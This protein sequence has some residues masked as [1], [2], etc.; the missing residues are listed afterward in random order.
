MASPS[1]LELGPA[2]LLP[3]AFGLLEVLRGEA[4][5]ELGVALELDRRVEAPG[6]EAGPHDALRERHALRAPAVDRLGEVERRGHE[7]H[8]GDR[9]RDEAD[10][11][12]LARRDVAARE[13][14][15]EGA[16]GADRA[17]EQEGEPELR[18]REAVVD[19]GGAEVGGLRGD[20]DVRA[21]AE[22]EP[23]A[24]R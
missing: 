16:R 1:V 18:R 6:L 2:A 11:R 7:L 4:H 17:R 9:A 23:A 20:A 13:H 24:D 5:E 8:V 15:L 21:E 3:G 19:A 10:L 22:A 12:R 14:D